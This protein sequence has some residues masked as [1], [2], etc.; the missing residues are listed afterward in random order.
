MVSERQYLSTERH[1]VETALNAA[2]MVADGYR[3]RMAKVMERVEVGSPLFELF[4]QV[5]GTAE[6]H[7][8]ELAAFNT[9]FATRAA[10]IKNCFPAAKAAISD[11]DKWHVFKAML[12]AQCSTAGA[13]SGERLASASKKKAESWLQFAERFG[14]MA[15][16]SGLAREMQIKLLYGKLPP[17]LKRA[18][19]S[20]PVT[21]TINE[22]IL[23]IR[24]VTFWTGSSSAAEV[25]KDAMEVD[26]IDANG[27]GNISHNVD[28][29]GQ[30]LSLRELC[31]AMRSEL[32]RNPRFASIA[33]DIVGQWRQKGSQGQFQNLRGNKRSG[34]RRPARQF[35]GNCY[36]CGEYGHSAKFCRQ[37]SHHVRESHPIP[38]QNHF[39]PLA[40]FEEEEREDDSASVLSVGLSPA[41]QRDIS[42]KK[43]KPKETR[44][45]VLKEEDSGKDTVKYIDYPRVDQSSSSRPQRGRASLKVATYLANRP[46]KEQALIDT[47]AEVSLLP[48]QYCQRWGL[49]VKRVENTQLR[50]F[51]NSTSQ[52]TG[53]VILPTRIGGWNQAIPYYVTDATNK[54]ILGYSALKTFGISVDCSND[55]FLGTDGHVVFCHS[56]SSN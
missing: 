26:A 6:P 54:V 28:S 8:A 27:G 5:T 18:I 42:A 30:T 44:L 13:T 53:E 19:A 40:A 12:L 21:A 14:V 51:N 43:G 15:T 49:R 48:L 45:M 32:A 52:V 10:A 16:Q 55:C 24:N 2:A 20:L 11:E 9:A 39:A 50:G 4:R 1:E 36:Q 22:M 7:F 41:T 29:F 3:P 56:V 37:R 34:Q 17:A 47:G 38:T 33:E 25:D 31:D 23:V 35:Q 46:E